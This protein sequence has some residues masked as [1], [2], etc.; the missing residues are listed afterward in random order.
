MTHAAEG[1]PGFMV[2]HGN[3]LE[4]LRDV[5]TQFVRSQPLPPLVPEVILV[6]SNG[7]KHWLEMALADD[8]ALGICAATHM[9]LPGTYLWHIY[10]QVLGSEAVPVHMPFDKASLLWRL[11]RL[12][13]ALVNANPLYAPLARY[14]V[15][16]ENGMRLYQLSQ[17][18]ADVFDGY[19]SYR[20]DW[21]SDWVAGKDVLRDASGAT[22]PL[23]AVH[24]WQA[25]LWRDIR[26][27]VGVAMEDAS[28]AGVHARFMSQ[29]AARIQHRTLAGLPLAG[30]PARIVVFGIS[31]LSMQT[32]EAL[33]LLGQATQVLML[34]QNPCQYFW[35][36]V[37][38]GHP[39]LASW[40]KQGRDY[41]H[42]LDGFDR[43]P[44]YASR[45]Q[46]VDVFVD[47]LSMADKP[48]QLAQMQSAILHMEPLPET[49]W[50]LAQGDASVTVVSTHSALRE[51]EVLHDRLWDWFEADP[52]LHA[53]EVMVMVPDIESFAPH[54]HAVFGRFGSGHPRHIPYSVADTSVRQTPLVK[55]LEQLLRLPNARI[56]LVEWTTLLE[57]EEVR[58]RF[59]LS[60]ADV[61]Q[62][63]QWLSNAGVRWGLDASHRMH[64]GVPE[65]EGIDQNTW[66]FG[67]RRL[68]LGYAVGD[69]QL[70]GTTLSQAGIGSLD[71]ELVS[72][73]LR[74]VDAVQCT[75]I[76][77]RGDKTPDQWCVA[78]SDLVERFF[79][80]GDDA[81][82]DAI[83]RLLEPLE[84]WQKA[85]EEA[86]LQAALPLEIVS[87]HWLSQLSSS[88]LQQRFFGGGVQF[89]TL[90]PMRSI[91]FKRI[92][93]LGM[94][95]GDYPRP[96]AARDFDLMAQ[97]WRVGDRS[98]RED[99]RYLL[100]E[101][102]LSARQGLYISW[103]SHRATDNAEQPPSVLIAQLLDYL[104]AAWSA[105]RAAQLQPLQ[106]YSKAY[107]QQ[108]TGFS[109]FDDAWARVHHADAT[110]DVPLAPQ[111][112][113]VSRQVPKALGLD[114]VRR[115]LRQPVEVF[116][117]GRL[118][119][120]FDALPDVQQELEPFALQ[121]L[122][123][124]QVGQSLLQA[125]DSATALQA[126]PF[127]GQLPMAAFGTAEASK[128]ARE[129]SVV[130]E[131]AAPW[132]AQY[133]CQAHTL[134][135]A[136]ELDGTV[137]TGSVAGL[138]SMQPVGTTDG[139]PH[140]WGPLLQ[141]GQRLGAV[142]EGGR[143]DRVAR[144]HVVAALWANHLV[145]CASGYMV[146]SV[147]LGLDGHVEF[148]PVPP[149]SA[150]AL[151]Q[152]L[153]G[154]YAE[155]W[156]RPLPVACK[157]AWAFLHAQSAAD[158]DPHAAAS[159]IFEGG[160]MQNAERVDSAYLARAFGAYAEL[161]SELPH[162]AQA[163]YGAMAA[164]AHVP[165]DGE[166]AP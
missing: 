26:A 1:A 111:A 28:R 104:N 36:D 134:T 31:S 118:G 131:R 35:G 57:V 62:L 74:W 20:A 84:Q 100:L 60:P 163:V 103:Q 50:A 19:Q 122:E 71:A 52:Q 151:L 81:Q 4:D 47:P 92:C 15:G 160:P 132:R 125:A 99:D 86:G 39:L 46:R 78:L 120:Q 133:P 136:L 14:L 43:R 67:L 59:D 65:Q 158:K 93:L 155:A 162:W 130:Q 58:T 108:G 85:C 124:Y 66:A 121:G 150:R 154:V 70:W 23:D 51:V 55:A 88:S 27:D 161:A 32:V 140:T 102:I 141:L 18:I 107:F 147:Q 149:A 144:A 29:L 95:D 83:S 98:R 119:V 94:N 17:Q 48:T 75:L 53:R 42:L 137:L 135:I 159:A 21:L 30:L 152:E 80:A 90:M 5:L 123:R 105:P 7:M 139:A 138:W 97:S 148:A 117:R 56:T 129:L 165:Q 38:G 41:L 69:G 6:Q 61:V 110:A 101:A 63:Q 10:R 143:S 79:L 8:A 156:K 164:H 128:L 73:L 112:D 146:T 11:M 166:R 142:L 76:G 106:P 157:T 54:I 109:T 37:V 96:S 49:P 113:A 116:F 91:P 89:G 24:G 2:L 153:I 16:D 64:W 77:L 82:E 22:V 127:S 68:L 40:G 87:A 115:L 25:Q 33:A 34:V 13:P 145:L 114:D 12:L 72:R 9:E 126:L 44:D 45:F 3:R